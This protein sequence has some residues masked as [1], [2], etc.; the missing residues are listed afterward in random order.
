MD[1]YVGIQQHMEERMQAEDVGF[2]TIEALVSLHD[3][4]GANF[5]AGCEVFIKYL[6]QMN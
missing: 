6:T 4:I 3:D 5:P 2:V 1:L